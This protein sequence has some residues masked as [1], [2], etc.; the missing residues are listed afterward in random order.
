MVIMKNKRERK[1]IGQSRI[2]NPGTHATLNTIHRAKTK[3]TKKK[4]QNRKLKGWATRTPH[5]TDA[6]PLCSRMAT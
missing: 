3:K 2:D 5:N 1:S 4:P 6:E